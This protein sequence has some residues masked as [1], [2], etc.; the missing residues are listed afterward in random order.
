MLAA[1][2]ESQPRKKIKYRLVAGGGHPFIVRGE[3]LGP[4][5]SGSSFPRPLFTVV[6][7]RKPIIPFRLRIQLIALGAAPPPSPERTSQ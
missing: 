6:S 5:A 1:E 7:N 2:R 4:P 3:S